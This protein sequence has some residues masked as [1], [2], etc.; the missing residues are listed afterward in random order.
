MEKEFKYPYCQWFYSH[1]NR[2]KNTHKKECGKN[3][4]EVKV[5][6]YLCLTLRWPPP[7]KITAALIHHHRLARKWPPASTLAASNE[8]PH[9]TA[10]FSV[11]IKTLCLADKF[12]C[13]ET[14]IYVPFFPDPNN[15][16]CWLFT[17]YRCTSQPLQFCRSMVH[18]AINIT[19]SRIWWR[20][21]IHN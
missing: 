18:F 1:E 17:C 15:R 5:F 11:K 13:W 2:G 20:K 3:P 9:T 8:N 7:N 21:K 4:Q 10:L 14:V 6:F 16:R 19:G 12:I